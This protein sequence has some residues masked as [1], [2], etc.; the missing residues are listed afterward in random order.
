MKM[1][2]L[3]VAFFPYRTGNILSIGYN[4]SSE[5]LL[6]SKFLVPWSDTFSTPCTWG[7][8]APVPEPT[9]SLWHLLAANAKR[10]LRQKYAR[11]LK[12]KFEIH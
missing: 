2:E 11:V 1:A 4:F 8:Q 7:T 5:F 10:F 9:E 6:L 3:I 12:Q